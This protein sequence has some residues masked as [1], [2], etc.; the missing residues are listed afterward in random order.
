MNCRV[1]LSISIVVAL[2]LPR[3][4]P[5]QVRIIEPG[6]VATDFSAG[7]SLAEPVGLTISPTGDIIIANSKSF[8]TTAIDAGNILLLSETGG[9]EV[10][11][12]GNLLR[13]PTDLDFG[14]P[15]S[16]AAGDLFVALEDA[17]ESG[18]PEDLI[19]RVPASGGTPSAF[20]RVVNEPVSLRFGPGGAFGQNLYV[21]TRSSQAGPFR[22]L[23]VTPQAT[24]SVFQIMDGSSEVTGP[25]ALEFGPGR[26][27]GS[28]LIVGTRT[29]SL[30]PNARSAIYKVDA[31]GAA[32]LFVPELGV[33]SLAFSPS[34]S[35]PFGDYVYVSRRQ[36][37]ERI[38]PQG[39]LSPFADGF[40][41]ASG[42]AFGPDGTL[43]VA[44]T[45]RGK[46]L[47]IAPLLGAACD[48]TLTQ[49]AYS[50]GETVTVSSW[51]LANRSSA[52]AE[53][54]LKAW[55]L[56]PQVSPIGLVNVGADRSLSLP[57]NFSHDFGRFPL[58]QVNAGFPVG[59]YGLDCRVLDPVT[60]ATYMLD[61]TRFQIAR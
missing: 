21:S 27:F 53:I 46:V 6:F 22:V 36:T 5:A 35:G 28:D 48:F 59:T 15:S 7:G 41:R 61:Q 18:Q 38:D 17:N 12:S 47:R 24:V 49:T 42:L 10:F 25:A 29:D 8:L 32:N 54:E 34:P 37:L 30:D 13:G 51:R 23:R 11:S 1:V 55:L 58:F 39:N 16:W 20:A 4:T 40:G 56:V 3:S 9:Q 2:T 31:S 43:Y 26:N 57:P 33:N 14:H 19:A 52:T 50:D 60:G 44:D 45:M